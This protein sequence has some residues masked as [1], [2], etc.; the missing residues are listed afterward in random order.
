[1]V[2]LPVVDTHVHFYDL[3]KK[4]FVYSWL[5]PEFVHPIIG[6]IDAIKTLVYDATAFRAESRFAN[7][8]KIVHVQAALGA[9]DP[10]GETA[11][12]EEMA[13]ATG[14]PNGVVAHSDLKAAGLEAEL[15]RHLAASPRLRGIRDFGE[16]DYLADP[17]WQQGY[18]LLARYGLICDLDCVWQDMVKARDV[19]RLHPEVALVLEHAGFPRAR[20]EEYFDSWRA[21]LSTLAEA[22]SASCKISGL[23]MCDQ[24]WTVESL[25][26]WVLA[27]IEA[28]G[29]ERCFFATN[30][31]VDRLYSSYDA[32][33]DA[34]DQIT[35]DL[36][37]AEREALFFRNAERIYRI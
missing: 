1:M 32:V 12:L 7:V 35:A 37:V 29:V 26:P 2:D 9:A 10:V 17:A 20:D 27:C 36:T 5:Q 28:F 4:D 24:Q 23:G 14:W 19:A 31:P 22:E 16:G 21:G 30:W 11:W 33:I 3:R 8:T 34:Y 18:G 6:D 15:E 25:R 13:R